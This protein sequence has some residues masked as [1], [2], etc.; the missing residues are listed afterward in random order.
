MSNEIEFSG[1]KFL[2]KIE[3][4]NYLKGESLLSPSFGPQLVYDINI[5]IQKDKFS[6]QVKNVQKLNGYYCSLAC[7]GSNGAPLEWQEVQEVNTPFYVLSIYIPN[8]TKYFPC[9]TLTIE[10][11]IWRQSDNLLRPGIC[12]Y[13]RTQMESVPK[14]IKRFFTVTIPLEYHFNPLWSLERKVVIPNDETLTIKLYLDKQQFGVVVTTS[15]FNIR[16]KIQVAV[17]D[18]SNNSTEFANVINES[19]KKNEKWNFV[20]NIKKSML[21]CHSNNFL[22]SGKLTLGFTITFSGKVTFNN[23]VEVSE[24]HNTIYPKATASTSPISESGFS[25][26]EPKAHKNSTE[27]SMQEHKEHRSNIDLT[28]SRLTISQTVQDMFNDGYLSDFKLKVG[29]RTFLVLKS[30][31]GMRSKVF[32]AMFDSEMKEIQDNYVDVKDFDGETILRMLEF[33][34]S[35]RIDNNMDWSE[36]SSLYAAADFYALEPLKQG[37]SEIIKN[38]LSTT[39][40]LGVLCMANLH[41]D[42]QLKSAALDFISLNDQDII[43]T[44]DWIKFEKENVDLAL[45]TLR[46]LYLRKMNG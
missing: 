27:K 37:C 24:F 33:V 9:G 31:L 25:T 21:L 39:S 23:L 3:N 36:A 22:R 42:R 12:H 6:F 46:E 38:S 30:I 14:F 4:I 20:T 28:K 15:L 13:A 10:F 2:W 41:E 43:G 45:E 17:L 40:A 26:D 16:I 11:R 8:K 29:D 35:D 5:C 18:A 34:Y 19:M 32:R 1:L 44:E 7:L